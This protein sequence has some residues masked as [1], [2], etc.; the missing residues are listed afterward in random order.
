MPIGRRLFVLAAV[1]S[2]AVAA[3]HIAII[4][5][6]APGYRYFGAGEEMARQAESGSPRPALLT[7]VIALVFAGFTAYALSAAHV[8]PKLPLMKTALIAIGAIYSLRGLLLVSQIAYVLQHDLSPFH[9]VLAFSA[10][11]LFIGIVHLA[12]TILAW[13]SIG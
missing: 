12:A 11:S 5:A 4:F 7:F 10:M 9:R 3:L 2:A 6:G 13:R 8:I 1:L